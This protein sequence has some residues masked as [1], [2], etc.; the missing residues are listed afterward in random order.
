MIVT[1]GELLIMKRNTLNLSKKREAKHQNRY[2]LYS[3][4]MNKLMK[5]IGLNSKIL[6]KFWHAQNRGKADLYIRYELPSRDTLRQDVKVMKAFGIKIADLV[7][8]AAKSGNIEQSAAD[9][10]EMLNLLATFTVREAKNIHDNLI[11]L[12]TANDPELSVGF[13]IA[14]HYD[15][16]E[17]PERWAEALKCFDMPEEEIT[18]IL[19]SC[20]LLQIN[21]SYWLKHMLTEVYHVDIA[22]TVEKV[23]DSLKIDV[24]REREFIL[25]N[26][27]LFGVKFDNFED[28]ISS[29]EG[30][31][32]ADVFISFVNSLLSASPNFGMIAV[33]VLNLMSY[34]FIADIL[35]DEDLQNPHKAIV[36]LLEY[37]G[38]LRLPVYADAL[39]AFSLERAEIDSFY[40]NLQTII[41]NDLITAFNNGI[42]DVNDLL[43][44]IDA[45]NIAA[46]I[47]HS[48]LR[49]YFYPQPFYYLADSRLSQGDGEPQ[50]DGDP[51]DLLGQQEE[52][53]I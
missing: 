52:Y 34:G 2:S 14:E 29:V 44:E 18:M 42:Y 36:P 32:F 46:K 23:L 45:E 22:K 35:Q 31:E 24:P 20:K 53:S 6:S 25:Y 51:E 43:E 38:S 8:I 15:D 47:N 4:E 33:N 19:K 1:I 26:L 41:R 37:L 28:F 16:C 3:S 10:R 50:E 39:G 27:S 49:Q 17:S 12:N 48:F 11:K 13:V 7:N 30:E 5:M 21:F 40:M 9:L